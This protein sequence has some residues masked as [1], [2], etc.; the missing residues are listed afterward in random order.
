MGG[1]ERVVHDDGVEEV[2]E[3]RF[4]DVGGTDV[5]GER[6]VVSSCWSM[7]CLDCFRRI[8]ACRPSELQ[9]HE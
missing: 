8:D 9:R 3:R 6:L 5:G 1:T 2:V 7:E 4:E